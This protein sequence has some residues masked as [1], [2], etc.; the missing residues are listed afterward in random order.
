MYPILHPGALVAV[1]DSKRRIASG[2]WASEFERPIYFLEERGGYLCG[3]CTL[4]DGLLLV[5]PHPASHLQPRAFEYPS[6]VDV[7]GQ[8]VGVAMQFESR[9]RR[10]ARPVEKGSSSGQMGGAEPRNSRQ[11]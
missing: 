2:G 11:Q 8:V 6:Q 4:S 3:W 5:Q 1:D 10:P 7:I 9:R